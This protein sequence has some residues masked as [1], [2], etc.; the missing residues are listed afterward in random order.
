MSATCSSGSQC[1]GS[2]SQTHCESSCSQRWHRRVTAALCVVGVT[3]SF[4]IIALGLLFGGGLRR[5]PRSAWANLNGEAAAANA[6]APA[7]SVKPE[8]H[9]TNVFADFVILPVTSA[10]GLPPVNAYSIIAM[11]YYLAACVLSAALSLGASYSNR[12]VLE[13]VLIG[14]KI[15]IVLFFV[16]SALVTYYV[17]TAKEPAAHKKARM[18]N[19]TWY[20]DTDIILQESANFLPAANLLTLD[21]KQPDE[22]S[23]D[24]NDGLA[25]ELSKRTIIAINIGGIIF[26]TAADVSN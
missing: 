12:G 10:L 26:G 24:S 17:S 18:E 5:G 21:S 11:T 15:K 19:D 8:G 7:P 6:S 14:L 22:K 23:K 16:S 3:L 13:K 1:H 9:A 2:T 25:R 20:L 4:V